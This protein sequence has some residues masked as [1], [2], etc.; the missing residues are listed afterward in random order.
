MLLSEFIEFFKN[1]YTKLNWEYRCRESS[2]YE[3]L[4]AELNDNEYISLRHFSA[5]AHK[6]TVLCVS[7]DIYVHKD[8]EDIFNDIKNN[9]ASTGLKDAADKIIDFIEYPREPETPKPPLDPKI[10]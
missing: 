1:N 9:Y 8:F 5:H 3:E 4:L 2:N 10:N 6:S 7:P